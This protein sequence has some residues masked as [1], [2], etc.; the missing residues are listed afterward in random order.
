MANDVNSDDIVDLVLSFS[1]GLTRLACGDKSVTLTG[2]TWDGA[3]VEGTAE[4]RTVGCG[5]IS[6]LH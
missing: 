5:E 6:A 4:V 2:D 3:G 1:Q